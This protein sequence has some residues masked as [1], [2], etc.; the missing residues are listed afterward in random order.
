V[1]SAE[2]VFQCPDRYLFDP[3]TRLC[4]RAEKVFV[5][6]I[7]NNKNK[8]FDIA[9]TAELHSCD[10]MLIQVKCPNTVQFYSF[11]GPLVVQLEEQQLD[12]FFS[13]PLTYQ[14]A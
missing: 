1:L 11:M 5:I 10:I 13:L 2:R 4:Q 6:L 14:V 12:T 7:V 3:A 8:V 9:V